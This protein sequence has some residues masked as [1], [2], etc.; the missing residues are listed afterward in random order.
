MISFRHVIRL[1]QV[2]LV[3]L[4]LA[5]WQRPFL[6]L[7]GNMPCIR[8]LWSRYNFCARVRIVNCQLGKV[9]VQQGISR[10]NIRKSCPRK[11][12]FLQKIFYITTT[13][14]EDFFGTLRILFYSKQWHSRDVRE[15]R[16]LFNWTA[17]VC[18][19]ERLLN[20]VILSVRAN[21]SA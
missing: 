20:S 7:N 10:T 14:F 6:K 16:I 17:E 1:V 18:S 4:S 15:C 3:P 8:Q 12:N 21:N 19:S 13:F 2:Q 11:H 5:Y 9:V